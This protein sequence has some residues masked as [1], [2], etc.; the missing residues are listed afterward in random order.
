[1]EKEAQVSIIKIV[2]VSHVRFTAPD[3]GEMGCAP[4]DRADVHEPR[5]THVPLA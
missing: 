3:L 1:M 5:E 2:D 4:V